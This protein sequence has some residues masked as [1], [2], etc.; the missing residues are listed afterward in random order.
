MGGKPIKSLVEEET[1]REGDVESLKLRSM[2][3]GMEEGVLFVNESDVVTEVNDWFLNLI[4]VPR[5]MVVGK[6]VIDLQ[7]A[8]IVPEL[9]SILDDFRRGSRA[10]KLVVNREFMGLS[11]TVRIQPIFHDGK[12]TGVILNVIDISDLV[13]AREKAEEASRF[14]SEFLTRMSFELRT[15]LDGITGMTSLLLSTD[16]SEEQRRCLRVIE[17]CGKT[18][19]TLVSDIQDISKIET[20]ELDIEPSDFNLDLAI[21]EALSYVRQKEE[22]GKVELLSLVEDGVTRSVIGHGDHFRQAIIILLEDSLKLREQ[23]RIALHIRQEALTEDTI[24]LF[25]TVGEP[26]KA[27]LELGNSVDGAAIDRV[28]YPGADVRVTLLRDFVDMMGGTVWMETLSEKFLRFCLRVS[29]EPQP[30][31]ETISTVTEP[32][33]DVKDKKCHILL[34]EDSLV[35]RTVVAK[36]IQRTGSSIAV[37]ENGKEALDILRKERFD[38]VFMDIEMPVMNGFEAVKHIRDDPSLRNIPVVAVTAYAM[39]NDR[40]RCL[41]AGMDDYISKPLSSKDIQCAIEKWGKSRSGWAVE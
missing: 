29:V 26:D 17:D 1:K 11:V 21:D 38:L 4:R 14:K 30:L 39:K 6:K 37:A 40:E 22:T 8:D 25:I 31:E 36:F 41:E 16:L 20:R 24:D 13:E 18:L 35:C 12:Y 19:V 7:P 28:R 32:A 5:E 2:I 3:E 15:P 34:V 33:E 9:R 23:D 10:E 27:S